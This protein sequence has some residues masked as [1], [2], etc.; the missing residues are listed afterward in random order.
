MRVPFR[1][2]FRD[3]RGSAL[4]LATV[5]LPLLVGFSVLSVDVAR[6]FNLQAE[7][8]K[9]ADAFALA[10]AAELDGN[11]GARNRANNAIATLVDNSHLFAR[12][13]D[14]PSLYQL[15][16]DDLAVNYLDVLPANDNDPIVLASHEASGDE[17]ARFAW[18]RLDGVNF[19]TIFPISFLGGSNDIIGVTAQAVA[20]FG[21]GVCDFT[22]MF[23]C[24]PY[25]PALS[26]PITLYEAAA[27]VQYRRRQIRM[28]YIGNDAANF[29]GNF[30]FLSAEAH[31]ARALAEMIASSNPAACYSSRGVD[32]KT[33]QNS[34]PV[35][36]A[37]N[38][39]F[40]IKE[41]GANWT[42]AQYGPAVNVRKGAEPPSGPNCP[43]GNNLEY[44]DVSEG[45]MGLPNDGCFAAGNCPNLG[46]RMGDGTWDINTYW[47]T[48]FG[49]ALPA[50]L[51][52][53]GANLP[54]RYQVY[55]YE[56][57]N[58]LVST[59]STGGETGTAPSGCGT[60]VTN[61]DRRLI[62]AAII[63]CATLAN[64]G[65][66]LSGAEENLPVE[67]FGSF[68]LTAPVR[69]EPGNEYDSDIYSELV[70]VSG[71]YGNGSL[72]NFQR[73]E[74]QLYR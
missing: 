13:G 71:R 69:N 55:Q 58:N 52:G 56:I 42:G 66:N 20:G 28:R 49:G 10:A 48:N 59:A 4:V 2:F 29:P 22:P 23:I 70:D 62:Y 74:V 50:E 31:G 53:T 44:P 18:V 63:N 5:M 43:N 26:P 47:S 32:T 3:R 72:Q 24:N 40:G 21:S 7:L 9:A 39:R 64:E 51:S 16:S 12:L 38:I 36:A 68:F 11:P 33:G 60:P 15:T 1:S 27:E 41:P 34:G 30:G 45:F 61:V 8:Q 67:A 25:D 19:R 73:D 35:K 65:Y 17:D 54:S 37:I 46:G 14:D 6:V 57:A